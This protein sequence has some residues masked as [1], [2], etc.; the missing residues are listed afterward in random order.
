M[1]LYKAFLTLCS[2]LPAVLFAQTTSPAE[3]V[4]E[5]PAKFERVEEEASFPGGL[6]AW[7]TFLMKN[8]NPNTPVDKGAPSGKYTVIVQFVVSKDGTVSN[9]KALTNF[10]Y[11][12][13]EEV[14]RILANSGNWNPARQNG[15]NV[16]AY[17][18]QPISFVVEQEDGYEIITKNPYTLVAGIDNEIAVKIKKHSASNLTVTISSGTITPMED[19]K[20]IVRLNSADRVIISVYNKKN[21]KPL[22]AASYDVKAP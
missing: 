16:N 9:I 11:G 1:P 7:K 5:N 2:L 17:R 22:C 3:S 21:G 20:Y 4:M 6:S 19:G 14:L 8:L 10:G 12:M 13:E 18:K 15:K